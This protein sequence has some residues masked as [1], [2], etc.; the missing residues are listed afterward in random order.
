M[1]Q[2][3]IATLNELRHLEWFTKCGVHDVQSA[4]ILTSWKEAIASC[5]KLEWQNLRLE[6]SNKL[7]EGIAK[8]APDQFQKWNES[9]RE[10]KPLVE[11]LI[12]IKTHNVVAQNNLPSVF[13]NVVRWDIL[14]LALEAEFADVISVSFYAGHSFWY[15]KGHFP[16][17]WDFEKKLI[18]LY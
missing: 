16:C 14:S 2:R 4:I 5:A 8:K 7:S 12:E 3:T 17:G 10:I 15:A 11:E 1:N 6:M 9:V 13:I 18:M